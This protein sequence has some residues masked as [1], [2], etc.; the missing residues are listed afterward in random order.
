MNETATLIL[1]YAL[2]DA[3][4]AVRV[5]EKAV[6]D[7][8]ERLERLVAELAY[9]KRRVADLREALVDERPMTGQGD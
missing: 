2:G 1:Q 6:E 3:E 9:S 8:R 4:S 5:D 7:A